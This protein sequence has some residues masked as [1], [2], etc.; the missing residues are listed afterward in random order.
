MLLRTT[1]IGAVKHLLHVLRCD[2]R[3]NACRIPFGGR[4]ILSFVC[5]QLF[6]SSQLDWR[7]SEVRANSSCRRS[8]FES[9]GR[10]GD[11]VPP[12]QLSFPK[13]VCSGNCCTI[14][15]RGR[16]VHFGYV[17]ALSSES[18]IV[19]N[20]CQ[21]TMRNRSCFIAK[22]RLLLPLVGCREQHFAFVLQE[23]MRQRLW[24]PLITVL[25][26]LE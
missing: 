10:H 18:A 11:F 19:L 22:Q 5:S 6:G 21:I 26:F 1:A 2:H 16:L 7:G 12:V 3:M 13:Y 25:E 20:T 4:H 15:A 24:R 17:L 9:L 23:K 8:V 14:S